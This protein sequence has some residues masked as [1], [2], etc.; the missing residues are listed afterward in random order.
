[1]LSYQLY[2]EGQPEG[3]APIMRF[4]AVADHLAIKL[5]GELTPEGDV[6]ELRRDT[7]F[8]AR[9]ATAPAQGGK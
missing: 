9:I 3:A 2:R 1:M 5:A 7:I 4:Q 6:G 8:I